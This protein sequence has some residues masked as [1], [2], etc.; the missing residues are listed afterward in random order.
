MGKRFAPAYNNIYMAEWEQTLH[1]QRKQWP[2]FCW[3]YLDNIWGLWDGTEE[4]FAEWVEI[5]NA[6]HPSIKVQAVCNSQKINFLDTTVFKGPG[7]ETTGNLDTT[8]FFKPMDTH[9]LLHKASHH[10]KHIFRGIV[11]VQL[12][13]YKHICIQTQDEKT[14]R[15]ELFLIQRGYSRGILRK[16]QREVESGKHR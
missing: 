3:R 12:I 16:I 5:L 4:E 13:R 14:A 11:K 7:C 8:V 15:M 10:P 1:D 9:M 2:K 6:P